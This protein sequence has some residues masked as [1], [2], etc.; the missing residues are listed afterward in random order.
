MPVI[1]KSPSK[2]Y[3]KAFMMK[4][5][6]TVPLAIFQRRYLGYLRYLRFM[7]IVMYSVSLSI[8]SHEDQWVQRF[9]VGL[10]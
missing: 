3:V 2:H 10:W 1:Q 9:M 6:K 4:N 8:Q 7:F 5:A